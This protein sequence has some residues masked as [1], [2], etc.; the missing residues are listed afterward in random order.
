MNTKEITLTIT[1]A[2]IAIGL[3]IIKIPTVYW[4]G[5]F[6]NFN[7]IPIVVA[8]LLFGPKIG[9]L[10]G[11]LHLAGQELLFPMGP[12]YMVVYPIGFLA[13]LIMLFGTYLATRYISMR[14]TVAKPGN[15]RKQT[16]YLTAFAAASRGGIM[17]FFSY[18]VLYHILFPAVAGIR[19]PEAGIAAL[20]PGFVL[21]NVTVALYTIPI[22]YIIATRTRK[23]LEIEPYFLKQA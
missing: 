4:P 3:N 15:A 1:F 17:P 2:A 10:V 6:Y 13:L 18:G 20:V 16:I 8:F 19:I 9:I 23:S 7:D 22:A 21:Y 5:N 12:V 11:T 14:N